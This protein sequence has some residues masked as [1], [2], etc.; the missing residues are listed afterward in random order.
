MDKKQYKELGEKINQLWTEKRV[1]EAIALCHDGIRQFPEKAA[2][3]QLDLAF[4]YLGIDKLEQSMEVL[5]KALE[6][7]IWFPRQY[8]RKL[9]EDSVF[10]KL[11]EQWDRLAERDR[12]NTKPLYR[13]YTPKQ[14]DS[15][16]K[17]PLFIAIHG[18]GE[19]LDMFEDYWIS[20]VIR[21]Q[22]ILVLPQ[23]SQRIGSFQYCWDDSD[24][25]HKE[26]REMYDEVSTQYSIDTENIILG[27]FSQGATIAIDLALNDA[28]IPAKGFIALN[29][30]KPEMFEESQIQQ[31]KQS[32]IKGYI[33]TGDKDQSYEQQKAMMEVFQ[34]LGFECRIDVIENWGHWFPKDLEQRIDK[35][36]EH[37]CE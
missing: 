5:H 35:G 2:S 23:S 7:D 26:L 16:R 15:S 20:D 9:E 1:E 24:K 34:K 37:I 3:F 10:Q 13:V 30:D 4:L 32:N 12:S 18:W 33:I 6:Q 17:Y 8:F 14:Y 36:I 27:G 22:Y 19:D 28:Y 21:Q 11:V 29:P 25:T 31:A